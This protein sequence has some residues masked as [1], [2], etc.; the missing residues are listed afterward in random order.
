MHGAYLLEFA[1]L[2]HTKE[3]RQNPYCKQPEGAKQV[4]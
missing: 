1:D 3:E 4:C 2:L